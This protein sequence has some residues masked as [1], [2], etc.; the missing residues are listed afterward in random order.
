LPEAHGLTLDE[1]ALAGVPVVAFD[2]GA[3][4]ERIRAAGGGVLV[5]LA[6]GAAGIQQALASR[7]PG[8]PYRSP[9]SGVPPAVQMCSLY[10]DLGLSRP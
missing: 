2:H 9:A 8:E 7:G 10:E 4:A 1:C 5:P 6:A 3:L